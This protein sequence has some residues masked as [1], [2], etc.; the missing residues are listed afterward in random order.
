MNGGGKPPTKSQMISNNSTKTRK[1]AKVALLRMMYTPP[2]PPSANMK[3]SPSQ[4][5]GNA[6]DASEELKYQENH[7]DSQSFR[8]KAEPRRKNHLGAPPPEK[9]PKSSSW[10]GGSE[11]QAGV[12]TA[13]AGGG[14]SFPAALPACAATAT[15]VMLP[16]ATRFLACAAAALAALG[17]PALSAMAGRLAVAEEARREAAMVDILLVGLRARFGASRQERRGGLGREG[18]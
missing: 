5:T 3:N 18:A 6:I 1:L 13:L 2:F 16:S 14:A 8:R 10:C 7:A 12:R 4:E 15:L 9:F 11:R 17:P